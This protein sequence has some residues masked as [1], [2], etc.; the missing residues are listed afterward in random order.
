MRRV[1]IPIVLILVVFACVYA[2]RSARPTSPGVA[3]ETASRPVADRSTAVTPAVAGATQPPAASAPLKTGAAA[4]AFIDEASTAYDP[5][6]IPL[7]APYLDDPD[8]AIRSAAIDGFLRLGE[9]DAAVLLRA[10]AKRRDSP[11]EIVALL[12]AAE[13]LEL[14][15]LTEMRKAHPSPAKAPLQTQP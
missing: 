8:P 9:R 2:V 1:L 12:Q 3:R 7:I 4:L 5:K 14:P 11:K 15:S 6:S 10:A 13:Y